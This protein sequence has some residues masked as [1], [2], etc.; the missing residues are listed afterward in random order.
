[1][2]RKLVSGNCNDGLDSGIVAVNRVQVWSL[3]ENWR[4]DVDIEH[5]DSRWR[6]VLIIQTR[7]NHELV[8]SVSLNSGSD[9]VDDDVQVCV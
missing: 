4:E 5:R 9:E 3:V 8:W 2:I 1:M 6:A 7:P